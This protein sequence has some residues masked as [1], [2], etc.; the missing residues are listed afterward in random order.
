MRY[1]TV[2]NGF[3]G[4]ELVD[5]TTART[6]QWNAVQ[7]LADAKFHTLTGNLVGVANTTE[8][9]APSIPAGTVLFGIFSAVELHSGKVVMY[10]GRAA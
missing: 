10:N 9:S 4:G 6:G 7:V 3:D 1:T 5:D 8:G 2:N